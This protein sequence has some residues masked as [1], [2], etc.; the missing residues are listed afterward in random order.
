MRRAR[1]DGA[2][3]PCRW[4]LHR[5]P[6]PHHKDADPARRC[7]ARTRPEKGRKRGERCLAWPLKGSDLCAGHTPEVMQRRREEGAARRAAQARERKVAGLRPARALLALL[8]ELLDAE[9]ERPGS[10]GPVLATYLA[11]PRT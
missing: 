2:G 3:S 6:C 9:M 1:S 11:R 4:P 7:I 10:G 8:L 5:G